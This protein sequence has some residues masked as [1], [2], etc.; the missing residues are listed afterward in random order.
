MF[1]WIKAGRVEVRR[2]APAATADRTIADK[3]DVEQNPMATAQEQTTWSAPGVR[4]L[5]WEE[6]GIDPPPQP[7][8][9]ARIKQLAALAGVEPPHVDL[10][11]EVHQVCENLEHKILIRQIAEEEAKAAAAPKRPLRS[12]AMPSPGHR[13]N[14]RAC[15]L[16]EWRSTVSSCVDRR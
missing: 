5:T 16:A 10:Y 11:W 2:P 14:Q 15:P 9:L 8:G 12:A 1:D 7:V 13:T 6:A 4:I 3:E